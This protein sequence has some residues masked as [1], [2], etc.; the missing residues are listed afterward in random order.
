VAAVPGWR[1]GRAAGLDRF[2]AKPSPL[3]GRL[4]KTKR[5][6]KDD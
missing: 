2:P 1:Q 5:R 6:P 3:Q 4:S